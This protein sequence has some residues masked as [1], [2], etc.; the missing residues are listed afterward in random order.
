MKVVF[1]DKAKTDF[2]YWADTSIKTR[3]KIIELLRNTVETPFKGLGKPEALKH[4]KP[5]WSR[6]ITQ[7][8]R[9][10]YWVED[11]TI[12]VVACRF[13]YINV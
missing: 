10:V 11:D 2:Q 4:N 13:H 8:H 5:L 7:E 1:T 12:T 9:L 3:D 6:R